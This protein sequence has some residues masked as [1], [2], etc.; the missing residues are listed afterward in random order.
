MKNGPCP[1]VSAKQ[2]V[3]AGKDRSK[4]WQGGPYTARKFYFDVDVR[5]LLY[6]N[7]AGN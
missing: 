3:F 7:V 2:I 1:R 6:T 5:K 4:I